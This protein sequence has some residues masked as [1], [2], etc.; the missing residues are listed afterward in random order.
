MCDNGAGETDL[1]GVERMTN[2]PLR[3]SGRITRA[4]VLEALAK[5]K[6]V[7]LRFAGHSMTPL[8]APGDEIL[9]EP[10]PDT[11]RAGDV[12]LFR[13]AE[14]FVAHRVLQARRRRKVPSVAVKGD[15][16]LQGPETLA[17]SDLLGLVVARCR[18]SSTLDLRSPPQRAVGTAL[19]LA[20]P[21]AVRL[22]SWMP[23]PF[24]RGLRRCL[25]RLAGLRGETGSGTMTF[26]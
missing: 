6:R 2:T 16:S 23:G 24:R 18:G 5:G 25:Y 1:D 8:L 19:A 20:S 17:R 21:W 10:L 4:L 14:T 9:V 15:H 7:R 13:S 26:E 22:A 3:A 12:V 11:L